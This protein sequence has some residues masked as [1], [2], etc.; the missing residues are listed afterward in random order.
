MKRFAVVSAAFF[1]S[2]FGLNGAAHAQ[3]GQQLYACV[4]NNSGTIKMVAAATVCD[5]GAT[6]FVWNTTGPQGKPGVTAFSQ[7]DCSNATQNLGTPVAF[8]AGINGGGGVGGNADGTSLVFQPGIYQASFTALII[9]PPG[10]PTQA[11]GGWAGLL[12]RLNGVFLTNM[13]SSVMPPANGASVFGSMAGTFMFQVTSPNQTFDMSFNSIGPGFSPT[14]YN[15][16][17]CELDITKLQ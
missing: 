14:F 11:P 10:L 17:R 8:K 16:D 2:A 12:P 15:L 3:Q 13:F 9:P 5:T 4:N 1:L 6:L 7:Y